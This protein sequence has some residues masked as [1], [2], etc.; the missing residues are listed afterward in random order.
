MSVS[1]A[2]DLARLDAVALAAA[3]RSRKVSPREVVEAVIDRIERRD[4]PINSVCTIAREQAR[5]AALA[6]EAA[7]MQGAPLG[8]LHGVP[9]GIKDVTPT[10]GIR[11]TFGSKLYETNVPAADA[12]VV[13]RL[14]A[15]GAIVVAKTN[16]PEF[17]AGANTFNEVFG[18]T[19]NPWDTRLSAG[20]S[21]GGGAAAL[22]AG[23]FPLA[24]GTDF[25]GSLRVPASFCGVVGLRPTPGLTPMRPSALPWDSL[26]V[27]GPMARSAVEVAMMMEAIAGPCAQSPVS[28]PVTL[29]GLVDKVRSFSVK[30]LRV[31][32][33]D[34]VSGVG[35]E[36]GIAS[37]C[38][39]TAQKL[40]EAG[41]VVEETVLDLAE[42]CEA[43]PVLRGAAVLLTHRS[44]IDQIE[45]LGKNL[46]GNIKYGQSL[47]LAQVVEAEAAR[48]R[49]WERTC[50]FFQRFDVLLTPCV[51]VPPF[52][53]EQ[54]HPTH[55]GGR[56]MRSYIDWIAPTYVLTLVG[57][58]TASVPAG[59][60]GHG[61]PVGLQVAAPRLAEATVLGVARAVQELVPTPTIAPGFAA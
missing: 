40:A 52:P 10:A 8:P 59:L 6:A 14:K 54:N 3:I 21:T 41:A 25:G 27:S 28:L 2:E 16:T 56:P 9:V 26:R 23:L 43:F 46:A 55:I 29:D 38:R 32:Y 47:T 17:A 19:R 35:I 13:R 24:E 57:V 15:A 31:G 39:R 51:P 60:D 49:L 20:G 7:V 45:R 37:L 33:V 34:D 22:A 36:D 18:V 11:T 44:R 48:A 30:G 50:A 4:G 58:P 1:S 5:Q 12:E 42:G 61:L 53:V